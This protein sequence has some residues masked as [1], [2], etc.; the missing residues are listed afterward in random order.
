MKIAVDKMILRNIIWYF[1]EKVDKSKWP[2]FVNQIINICN[3]SS[4]DKVIT[5]YVEESIIKE[6]CHYCEV[7]SI[8][9]KLSRYYD[10]Y[11]KLKRIS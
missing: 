4:H 1:V 3:K 5:E 11:Y 10:F 8:Y 2:S 9:D 6:V 7:Q